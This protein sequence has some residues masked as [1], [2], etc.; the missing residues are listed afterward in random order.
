MEVVVVVSGVDVCVVIVCH[1]M[2]VNID[3][4]KSRLESGPQLS[5]FISGSVGS[6]DKWSDY[7]GKLRRE[8]GDNERLRLPP[9][10]KREIPVGHNYH[11]LKESLRSLGLNTVCEEAKCPNI[12]ECW[13]GGQHRTSTATI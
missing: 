8:K 11:R 6:D 10:L 2:Y 7:S 13:G 1:L 3:E 9:W 5:Q 12:G 4:F